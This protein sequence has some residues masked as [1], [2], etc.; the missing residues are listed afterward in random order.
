[1]L[2]WP[3]SSSWMVSS[4]WDESC[5]GVSTIFFFLIR[6]LL[7]DTCFSDMTTTKTRTKKDWPP[8]QQLND[9]FLTSHTSYCRFYVNIYTLKSQIKICFKII[10][11]YLVSLDVTYFLCACLWLGIYG[12]GR[13]DTTAGC[14]WL[15]CIYSGT[16]TGAALSSLWH[17]WIY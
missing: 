9:A 5:I 10:R 15:Y 11:D 6:I 12:S 16:D 4:C 17:A 13:L 7:S 3:Q 1:M 8:L 14:F 2:R